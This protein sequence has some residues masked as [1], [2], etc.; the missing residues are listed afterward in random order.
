MRNVLLLCA[1]C[2]MPGALAAQ[3]A[4]TLRGTVRD[5]AGLPL[6]GVLVRVAEARRTA[7]TDET[8]AYRMRVVFQRVGYRAMV[9]E[10]VL[11]RAGL[12]TDLEVALAPAVVALDPLSVSSPVDPVLD[13]LAT[14]TAQRLTGNELR[15]L[16]VST[17]TEAVALSAGAV[18]E[19]YRGGRVGQQSFVLDGLGVKNQ[20]D[21]STGGGG[22]GV[23]IPPDM[24]TEASLVTNGFSAR[25]GQALSGMINV[26]T[27]DG[28][29][30][31]SG[32][33]A[34]ESDRA[35][36]GSWDYGLDRIVMQADGPLLGGIRF[37]GAVDV[38]ARFDA[39]PV[40][41]PDPLE[42]RDPRTAEPHL[43]P[44]NRGEALDLTGKLTIPLARRHALRLFGLRSLEQRLLFDP[45]FKYNDLHA[46]ARRT[47]G[48]LVS[49]H[50]QL[51]PLGA[52]G[53]D[54]RVAY[55]QR[56]FIRGQ[57]R[58][59]P[60]TT[61]GAFAGERYRFIGQDIARTQDT[62]RA[63]DRIPGLGR[64]EFSERTPWGV[65]AFFLG[66]GGRGDLAWNRF[67]ELRTQLDLT[68]S[69]GR[70]TEW[71]VGGEIVRQ[72]VQTFQ[73]VQGYDSVGTRLIAGTDTTIV[74]PTTAA[75]FTPLSGAAYV[76]AQA[77]WEDIALTVGVRF[78]RFNPRSTT[79]GTVGRARNAVS[80]RFGLSTALKGATVV[81]SYGRFAQAP[82]FQY[83][84]DAAF[85]DTVRTGRFRAGNP[86]LGF[87]TSSQFEFSVRARPRPLTSL[88]VNAF[89]KRL[90][91]LVAS[92]P[93]GLNPDSTIFG[94]A[95]FGTV[96]GTEVMLEREMHAGWSARV[97]Y[98]LQRAEATAT[99]AFQLWRRIRL[100]PGGVDTVFPAQ[101]EYPLDYDRRHGVTVILQGRVN[102]GGGFR[103][104]GVQPARGGEAALIVKWAS[105]L[106]YTRTNVTGDTL[107]GLPNSY[108]LPSQL[109]LD[110]LLRRPVD[111]G[112]IR[113]GIYLDVRNL[114]NRR[115]VIAV[116]RDNGQVGLGES[117]I[118]AAAQ[119]AYNAH[120]EAIPYESR[121]YRDWADLDQNGLIEGTTELLPLYQS[122]ARD[123]YQPLFAF[124]PPRLVRLGFEIVF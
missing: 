5:D 18:G 37:V 68:I 67:R 8:G 27:K 95:D 115:N 123:F 48:D 16:P 26:V 4:G 121:R 102:D 77:R 58:A 119:A 96:V 22:L 6:A 63:R 51:L 122:A 90:E 53:A 52:V 35:L 114:L 73:R 47:L 45:A 97:S 81:A 99:D 59:E 31:W 2:A 40:N 100:A 76:E 23:R 60:G 82:D 111:L 86:T 19:S 30:A 71:F 57:L 38:A 1:L 117:G 42:P 84:V 65:P 69:G 74:P 116:R 34:Y 24:L 66:L 112:G 56:E 62:A 93:F 91:G 32:R 33:T 36:P 80:P 64:P 108:R 107:I 21:A 88:R 12:T 113:G 41:A 50:Y 39:D 25:Y 92:V 103:A 85:D 70:Y 106:P 110:A 61:F 44:H 79:S 89:Y 3:T 120:P 13:P 54:L 101:V 29:D 49:A 98:S 104:L 55:F 75:S 14:S 46:P 109:T 124:G 10:S 43:L 28:G 94:N 78:D 9:Q 15:A 83:L 118:L 7:T 11:V 17:V 105:G 87:E 72:Q 20:L